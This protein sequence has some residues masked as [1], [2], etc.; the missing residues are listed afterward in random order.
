MC[1][2]NSFFHHLESGQ[3][4]ELARRWRY[5][6][7]QRGQTMCTANEATYYFFI[8]IH[9][10]ATV[11]EARV[12]HAEVKPRMMTSGSG[13]SPLMG[14]GMGVGHL[15]ILLNWTTYGYYANAGSSGCCA[16]LVK[17]KDYNSI[18]RRS[19]EA[20]MNSTIAL[21]KSNRVFGSW[22][23]AALMRLYFKF[24]REHREVGQPI[25]KEDEEATFCF[26]ILEGSCEAVLQKRLGEVRAE[27]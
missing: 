7:F 19:I 15:P 16:L 5:Q 11:E 17:K 22:S 10:T 23:T 1:G 20:H 27:L 3:H 18:L 12:H 8:I 25:V 6:F 2:E 26:V 24:H 14:K 21:V 13:C 4:R 9:G